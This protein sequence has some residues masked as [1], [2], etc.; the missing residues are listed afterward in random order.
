MGEDLRIIK[1][2]RSIAAAFL[3]LRSKKELERITVKELCERA[4]VNK[5]TFYTHYQDLYDLADQLETQ[6]AADIVA[7]MRHPETVFSDP[8]A[9]TGS[10]CGNM[11]PGGADPSAVFRKP[12]LSSAGK[13]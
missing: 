3:E 7:G 4:A 8:G 2:K 10:W 11:C 13:D 6:V 5:S 9:F 12:G 1:T